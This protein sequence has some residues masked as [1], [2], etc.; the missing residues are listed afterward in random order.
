[1]TLSV[2]LSRFESNKLHK[3]DNREISSQEQNNNNI[4][5]ENQNWWKQDVIIW[6]IDKHLH[7]GG[8]CLPISIRRGER[9]YGLGR[10]SRSHFPTKWRSNTNQKVSI[11]N[12]SI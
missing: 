9:W 10:C 12:I 11:I 5:D 4:K 8:S 6:L 3:Y 2:Y 7:T 1:M